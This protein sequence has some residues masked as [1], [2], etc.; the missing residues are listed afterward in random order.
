MVNREVYV[1]IRAV[2]INCKPLSIALTNTFATLNQ[3]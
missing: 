3:K 2:F 1:W